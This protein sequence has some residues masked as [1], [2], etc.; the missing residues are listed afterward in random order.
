MSNDLRLRSIRTI[1]LPDIV[2]SAGPLHTFLLD[3]SGSCYFSD[4]F[5]HSIVALDGEGHLRWH[6]SGQGTGLGSFRYPR[7]IDLGWITAGEQRVR[8][9]AVCDA[10][11][12]RVQF[13]DLNGSALLAWD[14]AGE[15]LFGE[16][17]DIRFVQCDPCNPASGYWLLLDRGN[18]SLDGFDVEGKVLFHSG[19]EFPPALEARWP[20][21]WIDP[22]SESLPAGVVRDFVRYDPLYYPERI[23]G[24][25]Q[26]GLYVL[27][28][29]GRC[30]K[31]LLLG[32]L[33]PIRVELPPDAV[34]L[35]ADDDGLLAWN[36]SEQQLT[37]IPCETAT[38]HNL[39][40][41]GTP[42][43]SGRHGDEFWIQTGAM[44][45]SVHL[46]GCSS[47]RL[48]RDGTKRYAA[49]LYEKEQPP[50]SPSMR[51][52]EPEESAAGDERDLV[53]AAQ[54]KIKAVSRLLEQR[55][56]FESATACSEYSPRLLRLKN[57]LVRYFSAATE[58]STAAPDLTSF[59]R[60]I[61]GNFAE[62]V[63]IRD[64]IVLMR[65]ESATEG[66][67]LQA[68]DSCLSTLD[69]ECEKAMQ[70]LE[71]TSGLSQSSGNLLQVARLGGFEEGDSRPWLWAARP[72]PTRRLREVH[73]ISLGGS[74]IPSPAGPVAIAR[75]GN[76]R[77]V[78][79]L[80]G[81]N[82]VAFL[83]QNGRVERIADRIGTSVLSGPFGVAAD[84]QDR[85]WVAEMSAHRV[86]VMN[87]DG[88][89]ALVIC[90]PFRHPHSLSVVHDGSILVADTGN[91][92]IVKIAAT[93]EAV[94]V[95]GG[96]GSGPGQYRFPIWITAGQDRL[97]STLWV[98]DQRNHRLQELTSNGQ[99]IREIGGC[100][101]ERGSLVWPESV[102]QFEDGVL[103]VSM[104]AY[105]R[106][107]KLFAPDGAE[108][109]RLPLDFC[110]RGILAYERFLMVTEAD[111][112]HI[113][114]YERT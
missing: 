12:R 81:S 51:P 69:S 22:L 20:L 3:G 80:F 8:C 87:S 101:L 110:A 88:S 111:G 50:P 114:V 55:Q 27:E 109:D 5:N 61:S 75:T 62:L 14:R 23:F 89:A 49:L 76:G 57:L 92:R 91:H 103:A 97:R 1:R 11:N 65:Y 71:Q 85:I 96:L 25:R 48:G 64:R 35:S 106:S 9:L 24:R 77:M 18:H 105:F 108:L 104:F 4:E 6:R 84:S 2:G 112:D 79:T 44:L 94:A 19:Q 47:P 113:R 13:L 30:L 32:N 98:V 41:E 73:R 45:R 102:A 15:R 53:A 59:S 74:G 56:Q 70:Q 29:G 43:A 95:Y 28:G 66:K 54:E 26:E 60:T 16:I 90:G 38:Q 46:D 107:V 67:A 52:A 7:G 17:N 93:G 58:G 34:W 36:R 83:D 31:Q 99:P 39:R 33:L 37:Y 40:F 63:K 82:R 68:P 72:V 42:A 10:W 21:P 100:G 78:V 86:S